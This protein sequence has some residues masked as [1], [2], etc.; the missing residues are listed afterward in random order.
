M[1]SIQRPNVIIIITDDQGYG[2]LAC[3]GNPVA[4]T[5]TSHR[6]RPRMTA[7]SLA[8]YTPRSPP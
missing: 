8:H 6:P 7:R 5:R 2:D 3:H 4:C 1:T